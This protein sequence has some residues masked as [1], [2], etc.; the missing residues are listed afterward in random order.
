MQPSKRKSNI[1]MADTKKRSTSYVAATV[2]LLVLVFPGQAYSDVA[3]GWVAFYKM[4]YDKA[5]A[6]IDELANEGHPE[7]SYLLGLLHDPA[8]HRLP[9]GKFYQS[10]YFDVGRAVIL[11]RRAVDAGDGRAM[12]HLAEL[13]LMLTDDR[14]A[15]YRPNDIG[16]LTSAA[17]SLRR[18]STPLLR[19]MA[20]QG[21][22]VAAYMLAEARRNEPFFFIA[23]DNARMMLELSAWQTT[24]QVSCIL[25][26]LISCDAEW[27]LVPATLSTHRRPLHGLRSRRK[28]EICTRGS[29]RWK[30][31]R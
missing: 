10:S 17:L 26:G 16:N 12:H 27:S 11:Y 30:R 21:N 7:A 23:M 25:A 15:S 13:Y 19:E 28:E 1:D 8:Y 6:E 2:F 4:D 24:R 18:R 29:I 5:I 3:D 14:W 9:S 20:D 31:R 22:T